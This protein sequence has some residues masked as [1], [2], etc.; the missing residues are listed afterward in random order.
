MTISIVL[1]FIPF[2]KD[3]IFNDRYF[4]LP[5][6]GLFYVFAIIIQ[7]MFRSLCDINRFIAGAFFFATL[8]SQFLLAYH[9]TRRIGVW[10]NSETLWR[11]C[12]EK[13]PGTFMAHKG[14][15]DV[16]NRQGKFE[17]AEEQYAKV[18]TSSKSKLEKAA[19]YNNQGN[20]YF[21]QKR[22]SDAMIA[23]KYV[24]TG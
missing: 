7:A 12:I 21:K 6:I 15:G 8:S 20:L 18:L 10:E 17:K 4:Y 22:Y 19:T 24:W 9:T 13:Y 11:D 3:S 23:R 5:G 1:K 16:Y 2:G 14:L